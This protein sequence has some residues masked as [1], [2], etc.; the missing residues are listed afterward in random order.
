MAEILDK[1]TQD[2]LRE[3]ITP[4]AIERHERVEGGEIKERR[5]ST[6]RR[7][8]RSNTPID[9]DTDRWTSKKSMAQ[10]KYVE[11]MAAMIDVP[12]SILKE[13]GGVSNPTVEMTEQQIRKILMFFLSADRWKTMFEIARSFERVWDQRY[14]ASI[15]RERANR[16][17]A[18]IRNIAQKFPGDAY[19][20]KRE[21][22]LQRKSTKLK[23]EKQMAKV[24]AETIKELEAEYR[25]KQKR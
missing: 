8:V 15:N 13:V 20:M 14:L 7:R 25:K 6:G 24:E 12:V 21:I 2:G 22:W 11:K 9:S 17:L 19:M 16:G 5:V 3:Y 18:P 10:F 4:L 23:W 1:D